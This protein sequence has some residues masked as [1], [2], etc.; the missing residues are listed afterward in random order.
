MYTCYNCT[1]IYN[2]S[3]DVVSMFGQFVRD[4]QIQF[5]RE[6]NS[7]SNFTMSCPASFLAG[8]R[9]GDGNLVRVAGQINLALQGILKLWDCLA[10]Y[11]QGD[12][13]GLPAPRSVPL[14]RSRFEL[15]VDLVSG[16]ALFYQLYQDPVFLVRSAPLTAHNPIGQQSRSMA[17]SEGG[18]EVSLKTA[19]K[20]DSLARF[21]EQRQIEPKC[22]QDFLRSPLDRG[23]RL[24]FCT[25]DQGL[26][27]GLLVNQPTIPTFLSCG[28]CTPR[29]QA[30][31][32]FR[33]DP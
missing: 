21:Q 24:P 18:G 4:G 19:P 31:F 20:R 29:F 22:E 26:D 23:L 8:S 6:P 9:S 17:S 10:S 32:K 13:L 2:H 27:A 12:V 14:C 7:I 5:T 30:P 16:A 25:C 15:S 11:H 28:C 1:G 3:P 33:R